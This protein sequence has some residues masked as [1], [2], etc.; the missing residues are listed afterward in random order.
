[1]GNFVID[2]TDKLKEKVQSLEAIKDMCITD[3]IMQKGSQS[4]KENFM[5]VGYKELKC[6]LTPL[7]SKVSWNSSRLGLTS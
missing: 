4:K 3:K 1:M 6:K 5:D 7:D 2:N